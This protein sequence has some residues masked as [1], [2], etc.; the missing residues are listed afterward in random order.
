MIR[1]PAYTTKRRPATTA[2]LPS[3]TG[4][5]GLPARSGKNEYVDK[6]LAAKRTGLSVRRLLEL[7]ARG[8]IR[9]QHQLDPKSHRRI[10]LF[11]VLDLDAITAQNG[12]IIEAKHYQPAGETAVTRFTPLR[13]LAASDATVSHPTALGFPRSPL[14]PRPWMTPDEAAAYSG[15][16]A[17]FLRALIERRRL[18]A[19]DVGVRPGGR[20]RIA[21]RD[22]DGL[23]ADKHR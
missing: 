21:K 12:M 17:S 20:W 3:G 10:A 9:K 23:Q 8:Q 19:L 13:S 2:K 18:P 1:K 6:A 7:A 14:E 5:K 15:L 22:L 4:K 11:N 16:P